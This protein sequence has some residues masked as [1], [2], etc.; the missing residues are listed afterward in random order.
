MAYNNITNEELLLIAESN[1][2]E[3]NYQ[4]C[5]E[6]CTELMRS[7]SP[8]VVIYMHCIC[9]LNLNKNSKDY[10]DTQIDNALLIT[11]ALDKFYKSSDVKNENIKLYITDILTT[12]SMHNVEVVLKRVGEKRK[13]RSRKNYE[14]ANTK[15]IANLEKL[16]TL[17]F[18][19][20]SIK[21]SKELAYLVN[22]SSQMLA[23]YIS[24]VCIKEKS[25]DANEH[26]IRVTN[27]YERIIAF[28]S[29]V[30]ENGANFEQIGRAHV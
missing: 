18:E 14:A 23:N 3:A 21:L 28:R 7:K 19:A 8:S 29:A 20:F 6:I 5:F 17:D 9:M 26:E 10:I 11:T 4:K 15:T 25:L 27:I 12:T 16:I 24:D 1:F 22:T 13:F 2:K 30:S